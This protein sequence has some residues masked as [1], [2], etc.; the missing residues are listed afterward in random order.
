MAIDFSNTGLCLSNLLSSDLSLSVEEDTHMERK[1][2]LKVGMVLQRSQ[3]LHARLDSEKNRAG[4]AT[5]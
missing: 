5:S 4:V 1:N 3:V 2:A